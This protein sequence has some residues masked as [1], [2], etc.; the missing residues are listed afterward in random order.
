[1]EN[2]MKKIM[3]VGGGGREHAIIKSLKKSAEVGKI[4]ALPGNGGIAADAE[5]VNIG[6]TDIDGIVE[7]AKNHDIGYAVVTPD[8]DTEIYAELYLAA[9]GTCGAPFTFPEGHPPAITCHR[10]GKGRVFY[11]ASDLSERY[12]GRHLPKQRRLLSAMADLAVG[13]PPLVDAPGAPAGLYLYMTEDAKGRY[14]HLIN[15]CGSMLETGC[16]VEDIVPLYDVTLTLRPDRVF[17][18]ITTESGADIAVEK[19]ETGYTLK[20]SRL[21]I[22]EIII[23]P[24][25]S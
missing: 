8:E 9:G 3:V 10:Y 23:L 24:Y 22:H 19:N 16:P 25:E 15:Y 14:L 2:S 6:A 17:G 4:Y 5:C 18:N 12:Y 20:L 7:F 11:C 21:D 1:M 13:A